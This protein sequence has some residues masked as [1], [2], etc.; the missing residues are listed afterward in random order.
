MGVVDHDGVFLSS[1]HQLEATRDA[2]QAADSGGDAIPLDAYLGCACSGNQGVGDV[3]VACD[4]QTGVGLAIRTHDHE[5]LTPLD[6][7][8]YVVQH[9]AS[10]Q[11]FCNTI[12]SDH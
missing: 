1:L 12:E 9:R 7:E 4:V 3:E 8:A 11:N 10:A 6:S 5:R 2:G